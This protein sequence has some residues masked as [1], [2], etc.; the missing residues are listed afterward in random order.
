MVNAGNIP[1]KLKD[2][3]QWVLWK[4]EQIANKATGELKWT[5]PPHQPNWAKAESDNPNTWVTFDQALEAYAQ[6]EFSGIGYVVTVTAEPHDDHPG[7]IDD[8]IAGVDL[9]HVVDVT[10]AIAPWAQNIVNRLA[11]YTEISP[12]GDGLRIFVMA[13]LP[14]K[15][16][17]IRDFECYESGRYLTVTGNHLPGTPMTIEHRQDELTAIHTEM[18][19]DRNKP[20]GSKVKVPAGPPTDLAD[21]ALLEVAF[22]AKNGDKVRRLYEGDISDH[23]SHS[24]ADL[25][26]CS[27]LTFYAGPDATKID[28]LFRGS[29]LYRAKWDEPRGAQTYG[30]G[31]IA[32]AIKGATDFYCPD[33]RRNVGR[34]T[35]SVFL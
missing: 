21:D 27:H 16:R 2:R 12:S 15:D 24:E 11:S 26:L 33:R 14:P 17:K 22:A 10:G 32:Y 7:T 19:A 30:Q 6:G 31:T 13:T 4:W 1:P 23:G 8:G 20:R 18:F 25:A 35:V 29:D 34:V 5:K 28:R 9:D 3:G